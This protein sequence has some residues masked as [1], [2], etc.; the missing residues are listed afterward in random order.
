[1]YAS[2]R[3]APGWMQQPARRAGYCIRSAIRVLYRVARIGPW[4]LKP[5]RCAVTAVRS[6]SRLPTYGPRSIT[7]AVTVRPL[8]RK[9][10]F[11]HNGR[12]VTARVIDRGPYVGNREYDLTAV[13]AQRLGFKGHGTILA[14]R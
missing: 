14:T 2:G 11:H 3:T 12:T 1:M 10:T 5:T 4:P 7:G 9:V 6:Y 13:T 8:W